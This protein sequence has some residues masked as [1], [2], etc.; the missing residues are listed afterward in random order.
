M[1]KIISKVLVNGSLSDVYINGG[2]I[3]GIMPHNSEISG[4]DGK[5]YL[6]LPPFVD[7][8]GHLDK[9]L[10]GGEWFENDLDSTLQAKIDNERVMR[11]K[12][13]L[14]TYVGACAHIEKSIG[15]GVLNMRSHVDIDTENGLLGLF[16]VLRA[17]EKYKNIFNLQIVAF[18][19]S[20]M[21]IRKGTYELM[22]KALSLGADV[23]G[24]ID[25]SSLERDTRAAVKAVFDLAKKHSKPIDFHLHEPNELGGFSLEHI[26]D[27]TREYSM[28]GKVTISHGFCLGSE[29]TA[30][31]KKLTEEIKKLGISVVTCANANAKYVPN[32]ADMEEKGICICGGNDNVRDMWSPFGSGDMLERALFIAMKH[33]FRKDSQ[34]KTAFS[35]CTY[36]GAALLN[37]ECYGIEKGCKAD[38]VLVNARNIPEAVVSLPKERMVFKNGVIVAE[39]GKII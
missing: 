32:V 6:M 29:N 19:Q 22:D 8:H 25:P 34:L 18:P 37:C 39:N 38:F 5:G 35:L 16:G 15:Y 11:K 24:G 30:M 7:C 9:T 13:E 3:S 10:I 17:R 12:L 27:L 36:N 2:K 14:D 21:I 1:G 4:F 31:T 33:N 28:E 26:F 20:G 23:V